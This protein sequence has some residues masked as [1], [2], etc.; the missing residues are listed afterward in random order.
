MK[1]IIESD[2]TLDGTRMEFQM[3]AAEIPEMIERSRQ[4]KIRLQNRREAPEDGQ[5]D[6]VAGAATPWAAPTS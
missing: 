3:T 4:R 5:T 1:L 2:G 6:D